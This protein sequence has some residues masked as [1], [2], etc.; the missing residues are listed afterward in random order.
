MQIKY[1]KQTKKGTRLC[2]L[3]IHKI[4]CYHVV[5]I[6][7]QKQQCGGSASLW[8]PTGTSTIWTQAI[9]S[10]VITHQIFYLSLHRTLFDSSICDMIGWGK[11]ILFHKALDSVRSLNH[12]TSAWFPVIILKTHCHILF[13]SVFSC[14]FV[15]LEF[16]KNVNWIML[17]LCIQFDTCPLPRLF[18]KQLPH[19]QNFLH[20][21]YCPN[22]LLTHCRHLLRPDPKTTLPLP[23]LL[24]VLR[25]TVGSTPTTL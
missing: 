11:N 21:F 3:R 2:F 4:Q 12:F 20:K 8:C 15:I 25:P 10:W 17:F 16:C 7:I 9:E 22:P 1:P 5:Y 14:F 23:S 24:L 19:T 6:Q 18:F 13:N